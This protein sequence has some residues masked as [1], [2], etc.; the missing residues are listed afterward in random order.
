MQFAPPWLLVWQYFGRPLRLRPLDAAEA[1]RAMSQAKSYHD[2]IAWTSRNQPSGLD[3][4]DAPVLV[5]WCE[6]DRLLLGR[7]AERFAAAV[8]LSQLV[9]LPGVGDVPMQD[10][11]EPVAGVIRRFVSGP[12]GK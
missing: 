10:D 9:R 1:I 3:Q 2:L 11:P 7:Q 4:I 8:P 5:A 6:K 12:R